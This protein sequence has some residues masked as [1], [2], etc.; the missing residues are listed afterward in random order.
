MTGNMTNGT[1]MEGGELDLAHHD[2][3]FAIH[4]S[5][6]HCDPPSSLFTH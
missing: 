3:Y 4:I 2:S 6:V 5:V 1:A